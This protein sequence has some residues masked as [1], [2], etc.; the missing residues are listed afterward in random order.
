MYAATIYMPV[1]VREKIA[2]TQ[3]RKIASQQNSVNEFWDCVIGV[4]LH[5]TNF[6]EFHL[7]GS[8]LEE[9]SWHC[10]M[11]I[12]SDIKQ[13]S[14]NSEKKICK[15]NKIPEL[16]LSVALK[17]IARVR[18]CPDI[19]I[20]NSLFGLFVLLSVHLFVFLSF[21]LFIFLSFSSLCLFV[22]DIYL[23]ME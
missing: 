7:S 17:N 9:V 22:F 23:L 2:Q 18:N 13:C 14:E 5:C 20:L 12:L 19:T 15:L 4:F 6:P 21:C 10:G 16:A 1:F 8:D 3:E 11:G